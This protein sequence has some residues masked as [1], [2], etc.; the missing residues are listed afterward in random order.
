MSAWKNHERQTARALSGKRV[1]R[2]ANFSTSVPDI[3]HP[4]FSVECKYRKQLPRLFR[5]G[6][7]QAQGYDSTK[8][9][10]LVIKERYQRGAFVVLR[11]N[12][13]TDLLGAFGKEDEGGESEAK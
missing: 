7:A 11:L 3:E 6:L 13:F 10:L 4:L 8:P 1:S 5:L 12:D 9:P 2:G